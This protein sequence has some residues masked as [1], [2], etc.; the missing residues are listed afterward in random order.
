MLWSGE[1][2]GR[3]NNSSTGNTTGYSY[4][5]ENSEL[6]ININMIINLQEVI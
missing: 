3:I 2:N 6:S 4:Y 5:E 1:V